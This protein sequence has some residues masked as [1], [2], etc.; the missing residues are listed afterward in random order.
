I[1]IFERSGRPPRRYCVKFVS[2]I[3]IPLCFFCSLLTRQVDTETDSDG[4]ITQL[5]EKDEDEVQEL[6]WSLTLSVIET[7]S[8]AYL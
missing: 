3:F 4:R 5:N 7:T 2:V 1:S 6:L 8:I